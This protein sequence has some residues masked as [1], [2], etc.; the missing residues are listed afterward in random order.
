MPDMLPDD[1]VEGLDQGYCPDCQ[2]R[3]F[4][5]GPRALATATNIECGNLDCR[6][7]FNVIHLTH[8]HHL[9]TAHRIPKESEGGGSWRRVQSRH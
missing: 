7:R 5:L 6:A 3:G 4:V 9:I 2:H 1:V 8:S